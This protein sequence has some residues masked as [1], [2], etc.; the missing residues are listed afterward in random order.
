MYQ[1]IGRNAPVIYALTFSLVVFVGGL[2]LAWN[3]NPTW[4]NRAGALIIIAGVLLGASR[5]Y[6][7]VQQKVSFFVRENY[8]S[9]SNDALVAVESETG[10]I[11][12]QDR[13]RLKT[14]VKRELDK[15]LV[16]IL[17]DG[18][19]HLK[20]WELY[21]IVGGTFLNGFGDLLISWV[22]SNG[23]FT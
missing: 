2:L 7:W 21:L 9:I 12:D 19:K 23:I 1:F 15:D 17:E 20:K 8:E 18:R 14:A 16:E 10:P 13:E 6:E 22:K 4:L 3:C 5:F 11:S